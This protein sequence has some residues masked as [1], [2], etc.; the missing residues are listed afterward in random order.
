MLSNDQNCM[1][2]LRNFCLLLISL[3]TLIACGQKQEQVQSAPAKGNP[4]AEYVNHDAFTEEEVIVSSSG[5]SLP[6]TLSIPKGDG[7]FPVIVLVHG[8]GPHDRDETIYGNKPF[9][10]LAWGLAS[11]GIAVMRYEKRA[12]VA[13]MSYANKIFTVKEEVTDD[14]IA[15]LQLAQTH[16]RI[17]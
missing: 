2:H 5:F 7:P 14:A 10:D 11:K 17:N 9:R 12:K 4:E 1:N 16:S 13:P 8:S 15:A 6:G 3:H